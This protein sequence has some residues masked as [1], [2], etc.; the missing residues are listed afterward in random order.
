M[1]IKFKETKRI[2]LES[3][4]EVDF[5]FYRHYNETYYYKYIDINKKF[6]V[7]IYTAFEYISDTETRDK[8]Y[9]SID[10]NSIVDASIRITPSSNDNI[11]RC[12]LDIKNS[13]TEEE[14][15]NQLDRAI[16]FINRIKEKSNV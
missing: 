5:P 11:A 13:I 6:E 1:K 8:F 16:D 10:E 15:N 14:F 4:V 12:F 3:T 7:V 2:E 9:H